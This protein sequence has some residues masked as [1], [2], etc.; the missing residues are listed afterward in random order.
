MDEHIVKRFQQEAKTISEARPHQ[1][2]PDYR[3][4][5]EGGLNYFVMKYIAGTSLEDVLDQKQP[6]TIDYIQRVLWE[7]ACALGHA[8]QRGVVHRDVKP[9][10]I[11]FDHDGRVM[12]TDFR[13]FQG[14]AGGERLH[15]HGDDHRDAALHGSRAG[16][17]SVRGRPRPTSTRSASS[18]IA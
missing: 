15:R 11:M 9:A 5:S 13:H 6:L 16:Q 17:G 18:R 4:E 8:H 10:N 7:A 12:L 14:A 1:H 2:H 3:V